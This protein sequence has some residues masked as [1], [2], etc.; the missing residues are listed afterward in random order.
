MK[1]MEELNILKK[2]NETVSKQPHELTEDELEQ[3]NGGN[4]YL[5]EYVL[6]DGTI[7]HRQ[8]AMSQRSVEVE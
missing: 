4:V 2:E 6:D 3:V 5:G 8:S 7:L 1:N